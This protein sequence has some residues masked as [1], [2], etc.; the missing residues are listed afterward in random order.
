MDFDLATS[1]GSCSLSTVAS[2]WTVTKSPM[3]LC[4]VKHCLGDQFHAKIH[5]KSC[6]CSV[7][8]TFAP[9]RRCLRQGPKAERR[10][11]RLAAFLRCKVSLTHRVAPMALPDLTTLE[12]VRMYPSGS[13][14]CFGGSSGSLSS[15]RPVTR[16]STRRPSS[17]RG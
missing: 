1:S 11:M 7:G 17:C 15:S 2:E 3:M 6:R 9:V 16:P 4:L 5:L 13:K 10:D 8:R 14:I 12:E